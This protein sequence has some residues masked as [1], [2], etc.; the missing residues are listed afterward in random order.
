[1]A[2]GPHRAMNIL[3]HGRDMPLQL[4]VGRDRRIIQPDCAPQTAATKA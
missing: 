2:V 3:R 4:W 1:M